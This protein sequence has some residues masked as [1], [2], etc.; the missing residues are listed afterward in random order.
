MKSNEIQCTWQWQLQSD[1]AELW[2][3]LSDT[4]RFQKDLLLPPVRVTDLS[5]PSRINHLPL[6]YDSMKHYEVWEEEPYEWEYPYRFSVRRFYRN[7]YYKK[8][9]FR[10]DLTPNHRGT[11]VRIH[12][13][14][15]VK[16][17]LFAALSSFRLSVIYKPRIRSI[18]KSYDQLARHRELPYEAE[19]APKLVRGGKKR[20]RKLSDKVIADTGEEQITEK[21]TDFL[22]RAN[23]IDLRRIAPYRL[24]DHWKADRKAV[25]RVFLS[26]AGH[27]LLNLNWDLFC[28]SCK[29]AQHSCRSLSEI[30]E[31]VYCRSCRREF[32]ISFNRTLNLSFRP[33]PLIRKMDDARY[34]LTGPGMRP[35]LLI[36][37]RLEVGQTRYLKTRLEQGTYHLMMEGRPGKAV[38]QV[39]DTGEDNVR[40]RCSS[41]GFDG[42]SVRIT[43]D[44]N[45]IV[46]NRGS[47]PC[48][49]I[50]EKMEWDEQEVSAAEITSLQ[51]FRDLFPHEVIRKGERLAAENLTFM[52]TDLLDSTGIY[53]DEGDHTA[54]GRVIEHFE[55][56]QQTVAEAGGAVVKTIGDSVMAVFS[57]PEAAFRAFIQAQRMIASSSRFSDSIRLKAGIHSGSCV[58]V[59]LNDRIDYFGNTVNI[60]SRLVD[61][62]DENEVILSSEV[63]GTASIS[64]TLNGSAANYSVRDLQTA[65][66]GYDQELFRVKR[67]SRSAPSSLRLVI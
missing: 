24:A 56:L 36:R 11:M 3:Y 6:S 9:K 20:L 27:G 22:T 45:L 46:E 49:I 50:L 35:H 8:W 52:F 5:S 29:T 42:E 33:D 43:S 34:C 30:H 63:A 4:D 38:V 48:S 7:G 40:I 26:A 2:P 14:A 13:R 65:I 47:S 19:T 53:M 12:L 60:A 23:K 62:A 18:L 61:F 51:L 1:P 54:V 15:E 21:L 32:H 31:P 55:I 59:N 66:R 57:T 58:A 28:P 67:I 44:P 17:R 41:A 64:K 16:N 10:V 39:T 25:L 37:Q